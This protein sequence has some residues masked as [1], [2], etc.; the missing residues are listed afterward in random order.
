MPRLRG[1]NLREAVELMRL[2]ALLARIERA[3]GVRKFRSLEEAQRLKANADR[4]R[5]S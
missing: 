4:P 2:G 5:R 1:D 3:P